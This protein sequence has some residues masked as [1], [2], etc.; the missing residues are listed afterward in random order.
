MP[1]SNNPEDQNRPIHPEVSADYSFPPDFEKALAKFVDQCSAKLTY[2]YENVL[3]GVRAWCSHESGRKGKVSDLKILDFSPI[4]TEGVNEVLREGRALWEK[5]QLASVPR[6]IGSYKIETNSGMVSEV[7]LFEATTPEG[8]S[9]ILEG[10]D[11]EVCPRGVVF[12]ALSTGDDEPIGTTEPA[13]STTVFYCEVAFNERTNELRQ[14]PLQFTQDRYSYLLESAAI[15][16]ATKLIE[17]SGE[18]LFISGSSLTIEDGD[19]RDLSFFKVTFPG[20]MAGFTIRR[21]S[22]G[23]PHLSLEFIEGENVSYH[24]K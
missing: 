9:A 2:P 15:E 11:L 1:P 16:I 5:G 18:D 12:F 24:P 4:L 19:S 7:A 20:G 14:R 17:L 21:R 10:G 8:K 23:T 3:E 6:I 22:N 13:C